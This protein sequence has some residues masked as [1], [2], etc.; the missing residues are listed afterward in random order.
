VQAK[1]RVFQENSGTGITH[2]HLDLLKPV[3]LVAMGGAVGTRWLPGTKSAP[4]QSLCRISEQLVTLRANSIG[5]VLMPATVNLDH[6]AH[7][8]KFT[9]QPWL[10]K[11]A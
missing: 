4:L 2:H 8:F 9:R 11:D 10:R 1:Q 3:S 5:Y 7:G 6:R